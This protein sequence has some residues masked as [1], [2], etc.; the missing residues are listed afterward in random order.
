MH[1]NVIRARLWM[2]L[3]KFTTPHMVTPI[4]KTEALVSTW[5]ILKCSYVY[6][7]FPYIS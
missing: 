4:F 5:E 6:E 3:K 1:N 7:T 2:V